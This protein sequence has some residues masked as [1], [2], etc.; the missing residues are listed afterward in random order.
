M[1]LC[2]YCFFFPRAHARSRCSICGVE[3]VVEV[4]GR[5]ECGGLDKVAS[6]TV[7]FARCSAL[8]ASVCVCVRAPTGVHLCTCAA[9][10]RP[11][12]SVAIINHNY[13]VD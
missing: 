13:Q 7:G 2:E 5:G 3:V 9:H 11:L 12:K 6:Y 8:P 4:M 1:A 10:A